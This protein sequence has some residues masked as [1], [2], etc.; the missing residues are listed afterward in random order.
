M[1]RGSKPRPWLR[2][3]T[4]SFNSGMVEV[5]APCYPHRA[6]CFLIAHRTSFETRL[7]FLVRAVTNIVPSMAMSNITT[8]ALWQVIREVSS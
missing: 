7:A 2:H 8:I 5:G 6:F 4:A 3:L 1:D